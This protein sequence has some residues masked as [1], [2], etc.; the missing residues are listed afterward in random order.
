MLYTMIIHPSTNVIGES[1]T[2]HFASSFKGILLVWVSS[3]KTNKR[4]NG[5]GAFGSTVLFQ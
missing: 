4:M 3:Y 2:I 5:E 1:D